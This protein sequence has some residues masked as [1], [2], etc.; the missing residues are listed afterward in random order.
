MARLRNLRQDLAAVL[1]AYG[2]TPVEAAAATASVLCDLVER[3]VREG[4][5]ADAI[6]MQRLVDRVQVIAEAALQ[7]RIRETRRLRVQ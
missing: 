7:Q 6:D 1:D 2:A 5:A 3:A 4:H